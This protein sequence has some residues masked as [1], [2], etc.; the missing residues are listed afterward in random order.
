M[1][2]LLIIT[3]HSQGLGKAIVKLFLEDP[4][5]E[6]IGISRKSSGIKNDRLRE[7]SLDLSDLDA[8]RNNLESIFPDDTFTEAYLINNAAWIGEIKPLSKIDPANLIKVQN[9]NFI[10]PSILIGAFLRKFS[11]PSIQKTICNISSGLAY[12]AEY[13]LSGYCTSKAALA[14]QSEILAMEVD[15]Q[16]RVF[17]VAPG[18]V[19]TP[20]QDNLRD[21]NPEDFPKHPN[22]VKLKESGSL[23]SPEAAA[24]KIKYMLDH[25]DEFREVVQDIRKF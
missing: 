7:I 23:V 11:K 12:R 4:D 17:S 1:N 10:S 24:K 3:G 20:M 2:K 15:S 16:T 8:V 5:F 6:V 25:G 13:G 19:D 21:T 18:V 9:I 14:M 22:F